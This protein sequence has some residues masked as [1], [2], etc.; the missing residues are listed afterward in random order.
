MLNWKNLGPDDEFE[1]ANERYDFHVYHDP[2]EGHILDV[3]DLAD[4]ND[5]TAQL[6]S[7]KCESLQDAKNRAE[8]YEFVPDPA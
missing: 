8:N 4:K 7:I 2:E 1:A 5:N 6:D 3:F